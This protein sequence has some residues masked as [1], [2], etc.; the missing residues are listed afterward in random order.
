MERIELNGDLRVE[1]RSEVR[2]TIKRPLVDG[3]LRWLVIQCLPEYSLS[4][5]AG[6]RPT[7]PDLLPLSDAG[8]SVEPA[9]VLDLTF[10]SVLSEVPEYHVSA[11]LPTARGAHRAHHFS[12]YRSPTLRRHP[13]YEMLFPE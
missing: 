13:V 7:G 6:T 8:V 10:S 12:P 3:L 11:E 1:P 9:D 2:L 5:R 4:M